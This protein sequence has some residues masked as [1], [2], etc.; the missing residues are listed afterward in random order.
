[1]EMNPI[2][3][4]RSWAGVVHWWIYLAFGRWRWTAL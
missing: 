2:G 4:H 1:L 3:K